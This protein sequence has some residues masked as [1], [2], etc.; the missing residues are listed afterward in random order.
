M[1]SVVGEEAEAA[2]RVLHGRDNT[3]EAFSHGI[4]GSVKEVGQA[5]GQTTLEHPRYLDHRPQ[6]ASHGPRIP[7]LEEATG[8]STISSVAGLRCRANNECTFSAARTPA[9]GALCSRP[10]RNRVSPVNSA[11]RKAKALAVRAMAPL[12]PCRTPICGECT[13][14]V[15]GPV[16]RRALITALSPTT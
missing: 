2:C 3:V 4:R 15:L 11:S 1:S 10:G 13:G 8:S 14:Q 12:A 7:S 5:D 6:S 16:P 9:A